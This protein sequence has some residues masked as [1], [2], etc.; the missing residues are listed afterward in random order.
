[1]KIDRGMVRRKLNEK[2]L[3]ELYE[4]Y[5]S[6]GWTREETV[7]EFHRAYSGIRMLFLRRGWKMRNK[8]EAKLLCWEK[9]R[10]QKMIKQRNAA[11]ERMKKYS[12][13]FHAKAKEYDRLV[14]E[15]VIKDEIS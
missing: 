11:R 9:R 1:M 15:G 5:W 8:A 3:M 6:E 4:R 7:K 10:A 12:L 2:E 13:S 14:K